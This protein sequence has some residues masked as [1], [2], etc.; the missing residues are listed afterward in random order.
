MEATLT[1]CREKSPLPTKACTCPAG[2]VEKY[3]GKISDPLLDRIDIQCEILPV[4]FEKLS[5]MADGEPSAAIRERVV[6]ACAYDRIL[7][8]ARTIADLAACSALAACS[9]GLDAA[10][11]APIRPDHIRDRKAA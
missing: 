7:K 11:A 5:G 8:V 9:L 10:V 6:R 4:P 1:P 2:V 3:L